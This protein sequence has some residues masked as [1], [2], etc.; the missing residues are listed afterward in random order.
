VDFF[1]ASMIP[2]HARELFPTGVY[3]VHYR[4]GGAR[5]HIPPEQ[6]DLLARVIRIHA[7][8]PQQ[9]WLDVAGFD[10]ESPRMIHDR[11]NNDRPKKEITLADIGL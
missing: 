8:N 7:G 11:V 1:P 2:I 9:F 6:T 3:I 10:M 4:G 5:V